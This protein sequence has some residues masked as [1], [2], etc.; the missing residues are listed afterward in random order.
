MKTRQYISVVI[1]VII[2]FSALTASLAFSFNATSIKIAG[3]ESSLDSQDSQLDLFNE[4]LSNQ[5]AQLDKLNQT[6]AAQNNTLNEYNQTISGLQQQQNQDLTNLTAQ[7][8]DSNNQI[9]DSQNRLLAEYNQTLSSL[10]QQRNQDLANLT[11]QIDAYSSDLSGQIGEYSSVLNSQIADLESRLP[12][13]QYDYIIYSSP[14]NDDFYV[15]QNGQTGEVDF[16]STDAAQVI[17][18][19]L[20]NGNSVFVKSGIYILGSDVICYNKKNLMLDGEGATLKC[21]HHKIIIRG[22][23]YLA[24][25]NNRVSGFIVANGGVRIENSARTTITNMIFESCEVGV[26]LVN[27]N[28]WSE[29]TKI[30]DSHF[31]T[32]TEG[33]AFRTPSPGATGSY[34]NAAISRC[35][36]NLRDNSIAI[37]VERGAEFTDGQMQNVRIWI[38][39]YSAQQYNQTGLKISG[40]LFQTVMEGVVFES[41]AYGNL[42]DSEVYAVYIDTNYQTP[43]LQAGI[44]F[45]GPWTNIIYNPTNSEVQGEG[46]GVAF[47]QENITIPVSA[48]SNYLNEPTV[49]Q[50]APSTITNFKALLMVNGDFSQNETITV[51]FRLGFV[52]KDVAAG[53]GIVEKTFTSS[54]SLWLSDDDLLRLMPLKD[55]VRSILVD[56]KVDSDSADATVQVSVFGVT[57]WSAM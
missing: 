47:K 11:G 57:T 19:A 7:I 44:T 16:N 45:L 30:D 29:C 40:S 15:A 12:V 48:S 31:I 25:Q 46:L 37:T 49:I 43:I 51:R 26:E 54:S 22:S 1:L 50:V 39:G 3:L 13:Q 5:D 6:L 35:Y 38:C 14:G 20:E 2:L 10:Q 42:S 4:L 23:T 41:F 36:F 52:D 24:S 18:S 27:T 8:A 32:C 56:A 9:I 55:M 34:G 17:N 53:S 28:T 33:I 21:T